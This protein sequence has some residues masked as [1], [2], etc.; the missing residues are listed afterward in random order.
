M[1]FC[2]L[3][4]PGI[5]IC[6][7]AVKVN[8]GMTAGQLHG[9]KSRNIGVLEDTVFKKKNIKT[10]GKHFIILTGCLIIIQI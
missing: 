10:N 7:F 3:G 5:I 2:L 1:I 4:L 8:N 6:L 9:I